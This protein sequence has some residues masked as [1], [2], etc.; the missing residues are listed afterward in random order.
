MGPI[1]LF[2]LHC[3]L[4]SGFILLPL[5]PHTNASAFLLSHHRSRNEEGLMWGPQ[6]LTAEVGGTTG[7]P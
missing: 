5:P 1:F 2:V 4:G 6:L 3:F 7:V